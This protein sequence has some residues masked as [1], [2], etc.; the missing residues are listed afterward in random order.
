MAHRGVVGL[1]AGIGGLLILLGGIVGFLEG[2]A[3]GIAAHQIGSGFDGLERGLVAGILGL[4]IL[5]VSG[6]TQVGQPRGRLGE[7]ILLLVFGLAAWLFVG[8]LL[9][10]VGGFLA[11]LGGL[12]LLVEGVGR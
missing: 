4:L 2:V 5:V 7:G 8:G 6:Y 11:A 3:V 10:T 1:L 12:I 9:I